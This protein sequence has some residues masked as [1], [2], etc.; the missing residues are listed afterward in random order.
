MSGTSAGAAHRRPWIVGVTGASGAIYARRLL[1]TLLADSHDVD[2]IVSNSARVVLRDEE[3]ADVED[4]TW[5]SDLRGWL[6]V[7]DATL[8]RVSW[9]RSEDMAAGP[10]S[11]SYPTRGLLVVPCSMGTLAAIAGGASSNLVQRAASVS[12]KEARPTLLLFREAP[13]NRIHLTNLLT[14]HDAGCRI[15]PAAPGFYH[16]PTDLMQLVDFVVGRV[17]DAVGVSHDL[18]QRWRVE[19]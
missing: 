3:K 7:E 13:L 5:R 17:L 14:A 15:V 11:G 8:E 1:Q 16:E 4:T 6:G 12:L 2:L 10:S 9:W 18:Y 19:G